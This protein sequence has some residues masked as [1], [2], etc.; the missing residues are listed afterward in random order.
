MEEL[1]SRYVQEVSNCRSII[2][3]GKRLAKL[4]TQKSNLSIRIV[5]HLGIEGCANHEH[6]LELEW[7]EVIGYCSIAQDTLRLM[8][9]RPDKI[10]NKRTWP[11][12]FLQEAMSCQYSE[13][14]QQI[15]AYAHRT[16]TLA[17]NLF[18]A[19]PYQYGMSTGS[20]ERVQVQ[21]ATYCRS[22]VTKGYP[23]VFSRF[24]HKFSCN[25]QTHIVPC[26]WSVLQII[27]LQ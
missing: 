11:F 7:L 26:C 13:I 24:S 10:Q 21:Q 12:G 22:T 17:R 18:L 4:S 25:R 1:A 5:N 9:F 8:R 20:T 14:N 16:Q 27:S 2:F 3:F 23:N 19:M 15:E 6:L